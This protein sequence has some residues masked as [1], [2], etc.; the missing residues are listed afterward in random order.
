M[1]CHIPKN[2]ALY[3]T[4]SGMSINRVLNGTTKKQLNTQ[5]Q[6]RVDCLEVEKRRKWVR[7]ISQT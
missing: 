7:S 1:I 5:G 4:G 3:W 6:E 2:S